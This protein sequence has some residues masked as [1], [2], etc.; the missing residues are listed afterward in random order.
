MLGVQLKK[1][2]RNLIK[3][4]EKSIN[5]NRARKFRDDDIHSQVLILLL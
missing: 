4:G 5:R 2:I 3:E 1:K